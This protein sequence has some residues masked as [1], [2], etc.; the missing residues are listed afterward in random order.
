[1]AYVVLLLCLLIRNNLQLGAANGFHHL[2]LPPR[3][4]L[5]IAFGVALGFN[6]VS[7]YLLICNVVCYHAIDFTPVGQ[8]TNISVVYKEVCF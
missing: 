6:S 8:S 7:Y 4:F 3:F 5:F 1:M 2:E